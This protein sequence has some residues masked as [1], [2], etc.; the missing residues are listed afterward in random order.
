MFLLVCSCRSCIC[1]VQNWGQRASAVASGGLF[2]SW[3]LS[4]EQDEVL[5]SERQ[6]P[7]RS[8]SEFGSTALFHC[9]RFPAPLQEQS[10][11]ALRPAGG[12]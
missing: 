3:A 9:S 8:A 1:Q 6:I 4:N 11:A 10:R 12:G 7:T 5:T 2:R